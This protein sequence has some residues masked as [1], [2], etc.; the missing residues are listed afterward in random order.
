MHIQNKANNLDNGALLQT[1]TFREGLRGRNWNW[2][3]LPV[4]VA[5]ILLL[6]VLIADG[7]SVSWLGHRSID[8][9]HLVTVTIWYALSLLIALSFFIVGTVIWLYARQRRVAALLFSFCCMMMLTFGTVIGANAGN[10]ILNALGSSCSA[11][12]VPLLTTLLLSFPDDTFARS[13]SRPWQRRLLQCYLVCSVLG[14]LFP[15]GY[16]LIT[17]LLHVPLPAWSALLEFVYYGFS[18]VGIFLIVIFSSRRSDSMRAQQQFRLFLNG[19]LLSFAPILV[20]TVMPTLLHFPFVVDGN[21]SMFFLI[22]FPLTLGYAVLRYQILVLDTYIRRYINW[23]TSGILLSILVYIVM[24]GCSVFFGNQPI[25]LVIAVTLLLPLPSLWLTKQGQAL[26]ERLF[27]SEMLHYRQLVN[28]LSLQTSD[29]DLAQVTRALTAAA[30]DTFA[31]PAACLFILEKGH[32]I[33]FPAEQSIREQERNLLSSLRPLFPQLNATQAITLDTSL[34]STLEHAGR[35]LALSELLASDGPRVSGMARFLAP[36]QPLV[37]G[38]NPLFAPLHVQGTL[39]AVLLLDERGDHESYAGPDFEGMGL[40]LSRFLPLL[41]TAL[42]TQE[43]QARNVQLQMANERLSDLDLLKNRFITS[44][45]HELRTPLTS[46][47]GYI[48][49]LLEH[50]AQLD[51]EQCNDFLRKAAVACDELVQQVLIISDVGRLQFESKQVTLSPC[52]LN[53]IIK[54]ATEIMGVEA[55]HQQRTIRVDVPA[56]ITVYASAKHVREILLNLLSNAFKYSPH[57][58]PVS[59]HASLLS[60]SVTISVQDSGLGVPP[61]EQAYLF[62]QFVR[63][64]RD[65]NSP[66][67]GAGLGLAICKQVVEAMGGRIWLTSNGVPGEGSTFSFSLK[68]PQVSAL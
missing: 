60:D 59:I 63:L 21:V 58:T 27:F 15:V 67:R 53:E 24:A 50:G 5:G 54:Q 31:A 3:L 49:L 39:I 35:P 20:L 19:I 56:S 9:S 55:L 52:S 11:V 10:T 17:Y 2:R 61:D 42:L 29:F 13:S 30:C 6:L 66:V 45:S 44:T 51:H 40:L 43:L 38:R 47:S 22:C 48:D 12:A 68:L 62:E 37:G 1:P 16:S 65:M 28:A 46:V 18:I 8:F 34:I 33:L 41:E 26:T 36:E 7:S 4:V 25:L 32:Y 57:G 23:M 14:S 64:E